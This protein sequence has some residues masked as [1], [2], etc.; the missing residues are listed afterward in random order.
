MSLAHDEIEHYLTRIFTGKGYAYV[1][2]FLLVFKFPSNEIKQRAQLVYDH[3]YE[4]AVKAGM[5]PSEK[6]E[7][8][9][10]ARNLITADEIKKLKKLKDQ[11]E[12]QEILLGKTTRVKANQ[13][14]IKQVINRLRNEIRHIEFKKSSKLLMSAETK[15]EEDR[16]FFVCSQC[17]YHEN[18]ELFWASYDMAKKETRIDLKDNILIAYLRFYSGLPVN[19]VRELARSGMWR[20][21]YINSMKTSDPLFGVPTSCY[22]TDQINLSYWSNY[23]QNIY[24]MMPEDRPSDMVI[25]DDDALDAYMKTFYEERTREEAARKSKNKRS[26]KLSAFDSEEVIVTRSHELYQ[27]IEYDTP[28]EAQKL[29]DR[30][31]I[32]KRTKRGKG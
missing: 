26:G 8:L 29:K 4:E 17:V 18:D 20:I 27:D 28:R 24:E 22:T 19:I 25:E 32:K 7:E 5:L 30:V 31:D 16:T 23:Y 11:L 9:V 14:R 6:L 12:A 21:R 1:G 10:E 15:A 2:D 3:S 13:E